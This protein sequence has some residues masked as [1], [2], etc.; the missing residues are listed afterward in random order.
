MV[1]LPNEKIS[2]L[3][4]FGENYVYA[5]CNNICLD[6]DCPLIDVPGDTCE[7]RSDSRLS[8]TILVVIF[9]CSNNKCV[10]YHQ[11]CDLK[12]DCGD[13]SD[14]NNC[15]NNFKCNSSDNYLNLSQ[16][17]NGVVSCGDYSDECQPECPPSHFNI[18]E[19][20][21]LRICSYIVGTMSTVL[22]T[23]S[24]LRSASKLTHQETY[25]MFLNQLGILLVNLG[26]LCLGLYL[27]GV[28][29]FDQIHKMS[30]D[31]C[32]KRYEWYS[33]T[34]TRK[35]PHLSTTGSQL[36]L[37]AMTM[38]AISRVTTVGR[39]VLQDCESYTSAVKLG[40][41]AGGPILASLMIAL[42]PINGLKLLMKQLPDIM[43]FRP[44]FLGT[45]DKPRHFVAFKVYF[46]DNSS[47]WSNESTWEEIRSAVTKMF[48]RGSKPEGTF[49]VPTYN[50]GNSR[51]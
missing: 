21:H 9:P 3:N 11:V 1:I 30:G 8:S 22:N 50:R 38:L 17:C 37:F 41:L 26:D 15:E 13:G 33:S 42:T 43:F 12:D 25:E 44:L 49:Q 40:I 23:V 31:Y 2:C 4:L 5:A 51:A 35:E 6:A 29:Y 32:Q 10:Q 46:S 34:E 24:L 20:N 28:S 36:S 19:N 27:I 7:N 14:E 47:S 45:I 18:F 48:S 16:V 39:M